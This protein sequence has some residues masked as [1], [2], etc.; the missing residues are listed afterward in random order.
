[1]LGSN[2]QPLDHIG[3]SSDNAVETAPLSP[4]RLRADELN[5]VLSAH[6]VASLQPHHLALAMAVIEFAA[7]AGEAGRTPLLWSHDDPTVA[8]LRAAAKLS[9]TTPHATSSAAY[10]LAEQL[11]P[12]RSDRRS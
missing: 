6:D 2:V 10:E 8:L 5:H 11:Q 3:R 4:P 9:L 12:A 1:M 7:D